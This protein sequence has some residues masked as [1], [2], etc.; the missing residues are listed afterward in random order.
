MT[1]AA[2]LLRPSGTRRYPLAHHA[3]GRRVNHLADNANA[4]P[5]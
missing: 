4:G 2:M 3:K 5:R 1:R